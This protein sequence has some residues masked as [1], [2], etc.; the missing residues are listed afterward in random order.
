MRDRSRPRLAKFLSYG[1]DN[2]MYPGYYVT[3]I[4]VSSAQQPNNNVN[5]PPP[6]HPTSP[7]AKRKSRSKNKTK[8]SKSK[9]PIVTENFLPAVD[10]SPPAK[11]RSPSKSRLRRSQSRPSAEVVSQPLSLPVNQTYSPSNQRR[12]RSKTKAKRSSS[13]CSN[14]ENEPAA[15][16]E[17]FDTPTAEHDQLI[18]KSQNTQH[19]KGRDKRRK[20]KIKRSQSEAPHRVLSDKSLWEDLQHQEN[21]RN[22]RQS[23]GRQPSPPPVSCQC[24][25]Y[26]PILRARSKSRGRKAKVQ[27]SQGPYSLNSQASY[28]APANDAPVPGVNV[29]GRSKSRSRATNGLS[30][31]WPDSRGAWLPL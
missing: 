28:V 12:S 4:Y 24:E 26:P 1:N 2:V 16:N 20:A 29:R 5:Y 21:I 11:R 31:I 14:I 9:P 7:L 18:V 23:K 15:V 6:K 30:T 17:A 25:Q 19:E 8:R 13:N 10:N 3:Q 27:G 22:I